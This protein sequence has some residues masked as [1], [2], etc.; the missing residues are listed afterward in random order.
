V[1]SLDQILPSFQHREQ[2]TRWIDAP[3]QAVWDALQ[4]VSFDELSVMRLG[5]A[6]RGLPA[7][8]LGR[9]EAAPAGPFLAGFKAHGYVVLAEEPGREVVNGSIARPW[10]P[11][12]A[13]RTT[14]AQLAQFVGFADPGWAKVAAD[15][16]LKHERGGTRISTETRVL[17]T[18]AKARR[19]FAAY[20]TIIRVPSGLIRRD[21]LRA[22]AR[23]AERAVK[24]A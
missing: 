14:V 13:E 4:S 18:D 20:W 21:L 12:G 6:L 3:P 17:T 19:A 15:F 2:H 5:L 16:R 22:I 10:K 9:A 8:L 11:A 7:R 1:T 24:A 23:R